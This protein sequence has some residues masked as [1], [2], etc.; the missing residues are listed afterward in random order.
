V[1][2]RTIMACKQALPVV[3]DAVKDQSTSVVLAGNAAGGTDKVWRYSVFASNASF[4]IASIHST[5]PLLFRTTQHLPLRLLPRQE[6]SQYRDILLQPAQPLLQLR[7]HLRFVIAQLLVEVLSVWCRAHGGAED[8]L[9]DEGVV[10]LEG[11]AVGVAEGVGEF[12]GGVGD[13]V[14]EGLGGEIEGAADMLVVRGDGSE[15]GVPVEP[16]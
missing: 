6:L 8:G 2:V 12:F 5:A 10:R 1:N 16:Y 15:K 4:H 7:L 3:P 9:H 14:A 13:V 11:F